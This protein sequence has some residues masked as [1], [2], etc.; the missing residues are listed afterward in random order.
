MNRLAKIAAVV[1]LALIATAALARTERGSFL[2]RPA[3]NHDALM[4]Q[5]RTDPVVADRFMRHFG[6]TKDE[7]VD[8]MDGLRLQ[9]LQADGVFVV[10]N[11]PGTEE[12]RSKPLFFRNGTLV[13]VNQVGVPVLKASCGNPLVRGTD[14]GT[15]LVTPSVTASRPAAPIAVSPIP[16]TVPVSTPIASFQPDLPIASAQNLVV[17]PDAPEVS[18]QSLVLP[19]IL[20]VTAGLLLG[21]DRGDTNPVPEPGTMLTLAA[22]AA[23][24]AA[25]RRKKRD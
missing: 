10:Y 3:P 4:S 9:R 16:N 23:L 20:P 8:Y 22:G 2:N 25:R 15:A 14:I 19:F 24:V 6:M 11:V 21:L 18:R 13:W 1:A 5:V 17:E 12:L 7:I